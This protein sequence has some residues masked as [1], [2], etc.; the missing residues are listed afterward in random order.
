MTVAWALLGFI[1]FATW[2]PQTLRPHLGDPQL[3]RFGAF[4]VTS[5]A[6]AFAYPRRPLVIAAAAVFAAVFLELG[7]L[8]IPGRDAGIPDAIAKSLGGLAGAA[9]AAGASRI[10]RLV[11]KSR[12]GGVA[13]SD[14]KSHDLGRRVVL[15]RT[16]LPLFKAAKRS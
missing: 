9:V 13:L 15:R 7:Q 16:R 3:E 14:A 11:N 8:F 4:F 6:F 12:G 1:V 2:G 10:F 5:I